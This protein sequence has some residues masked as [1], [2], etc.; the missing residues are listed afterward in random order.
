MPDNEFLLPDFILLTDHNNDWDEYI[1][2]LYKAFTADFI[3]TPPS[4]KGIRLRLKRHPVADGKEA[5]FWHMISTGEDENNRSYD[6]E[7]CKR[8][9]WPNPIIN[10]VDHEQLRVWKTKR[11][12]DD[13]ILILFEE[14]R[15]LV[16]LTERRGYLLP[17]TAY[18]IERNHRLRKLIREHER[19]LQTN[20]AQ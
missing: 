8:I 14:R 15:Y 4:Y 16:V 7:R 17:W 13:R 3:T 1:E 6:E 18:Y 10:N 19:Y 5:T 11:G 9:R 12:S 20:I 2:A